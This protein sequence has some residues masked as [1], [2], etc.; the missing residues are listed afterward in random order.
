MIRRF[1]FVLCCA[2]LG[3]AHRQEPLVTPAEAASARAD[4]EL[5]QR[6]VK[7]DVPGWHCQQDRITGTA[8]ARYVCYPPE[9]KKEQIGA[10]YYRVF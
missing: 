7:N 8:V 6:I 2:F 5:F 1:A 10:S 9:Y 3:C 4:K